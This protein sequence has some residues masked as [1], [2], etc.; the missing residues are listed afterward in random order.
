MFTIYN[1]LQHLQHVS[2]PTPKHYI[3]PNLDVIKY[4]VS[5]QF[6]FRISAT[7]V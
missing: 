3:I 6:Y 5:R 4:T 7:R 2:A 1:Q